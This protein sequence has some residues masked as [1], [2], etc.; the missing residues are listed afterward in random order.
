MATVDARARAA[1]RDRGDA[2]ATAVITV[3]LVLIAAAVIYI[4]RQKAVDT[5]NNICTN[6][7]PTTCQ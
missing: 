1:R 3:G 7:D 5:A 2:L 4:I 6:T